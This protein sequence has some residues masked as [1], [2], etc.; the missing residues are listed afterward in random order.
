MCEE[1]L[2]AFKQASPTLS[3]VAG[4]RCRPTSWPCCMLY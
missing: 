4:I 3:S 2:I 1:Q